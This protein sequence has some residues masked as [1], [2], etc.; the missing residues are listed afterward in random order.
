MTRR[1]VLDSP[2]LIYRAFFALPAT[3]RS[4]HGTPVNAIRGYLDMVAHLLRTEKPGMVIHT[5]DEDWRPQW[6]VD[7][8]SGYKAQRRD[9]PGELPPQFPIIQ[10][11]VD[12]LGH[13]RVGMPAHEADDVIGTLAA[14]ATAN[15]PVVVVSGDRDMLQLVRDP[16]VLVLFPV[17][18]VKEVHRYDEAEVL[19]RQGVPAARYADYAILRGDTSD[20]LPGL[21]GVGA[22]TA[23]QLVRGYPSIEALIAGARRESLRL[24][25][26]IA[27]Q[28]DYLRAMTQIVPVVRD[29]ALPDLV[30]GVPDRSALDALG[31]QHGIESPVSRL[32]DATEA[33]LRS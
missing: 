29:L 13:P 8:Y 1:L 5:F 17:K 14:R 27:Q 26:A 30:Q 11:V 24:S 4:P 28:A 21:R 12:A 19:S 25:Q 15:E 20:G 18:G 31:Q 16:E 3:I 33:M 32:L 22:K 9:D 7:A 23:A 6:R 10:A 2:S